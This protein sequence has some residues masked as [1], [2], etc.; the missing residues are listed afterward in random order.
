MEPA[1]NPF[2]WVLSLFTGTVFTPKRTLADDEKEWEKLTEGQIRD[3][4]LLL[5]KA[6]GDMEDLMDFS[7]NSAK[8]GFDSLSYLM[9]LGRAARMMDWADADAYELGHRYAHLM[10]ASEAGVVNAA[11][12]PKGET[13]RSAMER[14][15]HGIDAD[16]A[17]LLNFVKRRNDELENALESRDFTGGEPLASAYVK[18]KSE[19]ARS[20]PSQWVAYRKRQQEEEVAMEAAPSSVASGSAAG[21]AGGVVAGAGA[22]P[23]SARDSAAGRGRVASDSLSGSGGGR[24]GGSH[25]AAASLSRPPIAPVYAARQATARQQQGTGAGA[26]AAATTAFGT[27][28][29]TDAG[30]GSGS[31]ESSRRPSSRTSLAGAGGG[32]GAGRGPGGSGIALAARGLGG[33]GAMPETPQLLDPAADDLARQYHARSAAGAGAGG[34]SG[35]AA[36]TRKPTIKAT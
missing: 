30:H 7:R 33:A 22:S 36:A 6:I 28:A 26:G 8:A 12:A 9:L 3:Q 10:W 5:D 27:G 17:D 24:G 4:V 18:G 35:A 31:Q 23:L 21:T 20:Y 2:S 11:L 14:E 32:A 34:A 19:F 15:E 1:F 16:A 29:A 13:L 25:A